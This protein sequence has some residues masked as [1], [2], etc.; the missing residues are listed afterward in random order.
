MVGFT[1]KPKD[2]AHLLGGS[3]I[4]RQPIR[5]SHG[6]FPL[7]HGKTSGPAVGSKMVSLP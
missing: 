4:E 5:L 3:P 1:F 2:T 6:Q 7:G